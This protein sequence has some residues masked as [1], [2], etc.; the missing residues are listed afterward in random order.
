MGRQ[1]AA[2][3]ALMT[4][5]AVESQPTPDDLRIPARGGSPIR[6]GLC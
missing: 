2:D 3:Q 5:L 6:T 1:I 4:K